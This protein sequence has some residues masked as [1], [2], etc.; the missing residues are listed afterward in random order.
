MEHTLSHMARQY[1]RRIRE[2]VE[3]HGWDGLDLFLYREI[4][5]ERERRKMEEGKVIAPPLRRV[6]NEATPLSASALLE[7]E[8]MRARQ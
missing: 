7:R 2:Y 5:T 8:L 3:E 4:Y 1:G 6:R